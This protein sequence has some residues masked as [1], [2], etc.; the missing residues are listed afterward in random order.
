MALSGSGKDVSVQSKTRRGRNSFPSFAPLLLCV[1]VRF[2]LQVKVADL[3]LEL[4][5]VILA[6][7]KCLPVRYNSI[8]M[9]Y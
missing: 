1:L 4:R 3:T 7:S 8:S 2:N 6:G 5:I 9:L